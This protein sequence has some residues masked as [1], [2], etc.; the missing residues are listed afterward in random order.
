[1]PPSYQSNPIVGP[2]TVTVAFSNGVDFK[3]EFRGYTERDQL[4]FAGNPPGFSDIV[5]K[6][7]LPKA[8]RTNCGGLFPT[9]MS[10]E[11]SA[12]SDS[13][14][15]GQTEGNGILADYLSKHSDARE[16]DALS[17]VNEALPTGVKQWTLVGLRKNGIWREH[18]ERRIGEY[19]D[20]NPDASLKR[21]G[22][23][24]GLAK[25]TVST[26]EAYQARKEKRKADKLPSKGKARGNLTDKQL[27]GIE[28]GKQLP[29][30]PARDA[31][32][33][34]AYSADGDVHTDPN[35]FRSLLLNIFEDGSEY[36]EKVHRLSKVLLTELIQH[37]KDKIDPGKA[38]LL[39]LTVEQ[40]LDDRS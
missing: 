8:E 7:E 5:Y 2:N 36:R 35:A 13:A 20:T 18:V 29:R 12:G 34:D 25:S 11:R 22:K 16:V 15:G 1:M 30:D 27:A 9:F 40:W 37:V 3:G 24:V 17:A 10:E 21:I 28:S 26:S 31:L 23:N 39:R 19:M 6:W 38:E 4:Y 32:H 33:A 14:E